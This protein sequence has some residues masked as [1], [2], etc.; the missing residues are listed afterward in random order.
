MKQKLSYIVFPA[1]FLLGILLVLL[2]EGARE[3]EQIQGEVVRFHVVGESNSAADQQLKIQV[4]D[5]V[6]GLIQSLF[7]DCTAQEEALEIA[8]ENR[9][10]LQACAEQILRENGSDSP[11]TVE[12]GER[13]FPTKDYG[14]FSFPAGR[15]EAVSI[16]IGA[17][18]GENF[19]C[20]LY[21][22]LCIAPAVA[23]EQAEDEMTAILGEEQTNFLKKEDSGQKIKFALAEFWGYLMEKFDNL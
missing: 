23:E 1:L 6:F 5:G 2:F 20:V 4:R 19:W 21:P 8:R 16:R 11:V 3:A 14:S 17:A 13:F 12:I 7:S 10:R 9:P 15:Y 18:E 22:A